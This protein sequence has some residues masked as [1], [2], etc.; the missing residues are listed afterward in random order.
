MSSAEYL[1]SGGVSLGRHGPAVGLAGRWR[2]GVLAVVGAGAWAAELLLD[3]TTAGRGTAR[4]HDRLREHRPRPGRRPEDRGAAHTARVPVV[5]DDVGSRDRRRRPRVALRPGEGLQR[6]RRPPTTAT[7]SSRGWGPDGAS[8]RST[9]GRTA[10]AGVVGGAGERRGRCREGTHR[11]AVTGR[12]DRR[13]RGG[14]D[15]QPRVVR[16]PRRGAVLGRFQD[17][18]DRVTSTRPTRRWSDDADF[19]HWTGRD[20]RVAGSTL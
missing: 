11:A 5:Q 15:L 4:L 18:V 10:R 3:R 1:E 8:R 2:V 7:T 6:L 20:R 9:P 12:R 17:V 16:G 13:R 14:P 19:Q